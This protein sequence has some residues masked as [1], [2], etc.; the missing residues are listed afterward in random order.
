MTT[1]KGKEAH[2]GVTLDIIWEAGKGSSMRSVA[3]EPQ[4]CGS[5]NSQGEHL[6]L[7][8]TL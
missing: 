7:N 8:Q 6:K 5:A 1:T 3:R 4:Q 2:A